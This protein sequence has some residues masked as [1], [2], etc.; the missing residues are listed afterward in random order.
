MNI[1]LRKTMKVLG[2]SLF[3]P[4]RSHS[5]SLKDQCSEGECLA[6]RFTSKV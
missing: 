2:G 4:T 6:E 5:Y 3:P 1:Y